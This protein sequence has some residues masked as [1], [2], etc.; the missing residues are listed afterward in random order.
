MPTNSDFLFHKTV[1]SKGGG[2]LQAGG[3]GIATKT[4]QLLGGCVGRV[5]RGKVKGRKKGVKG[6]KTGAKGG[7]K[8]VKR[9]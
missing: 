1:A 3:V 7:K 2:W 5:L 4:A 8:G 9:V 6:G